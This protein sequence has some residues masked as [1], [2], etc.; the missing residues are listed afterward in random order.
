MT[1]ERLREIERLF[2]EAR[3]RTPAERDAWLARACAD[4]P[5]LRREVESLLAQPPAGMIDAPVGAL[6]AGLVTPASV[7]LT[8]RR[9]GVFEVQ[10]LLGVGGMGEVY[11]A[12]DTRLGRDVAIKIL[13]R[14]FKDDPDRLARFEREARVLASLNHPHIG[15]IYG[16]EEADDVTALVMELVEG[17]DLAQRLARGADP[18]R[19]G[20]AHRDADRGSPRSGARAGHHPSRSE[21]REHQGAHRRHG[22]GPGFRS[23]EGV[24]RDRLASPS[25]TTSPTSRL[26]PRKPASS[27]GRPRT[28]RRSRRRARPVDKRADLWSFG[29]RALRDA[30]RAPALRGR[31]DFRRAGEDHRAR[32]GLDGAPREDAAHR[33]GRCCGAVSKRIRSGGSIRRP[34]R[35]WRLKRRSTTAGADG[36]PVSGVDARRA[37]WPTT[38]L[39]AVAVLAARRRRGDDVDGEAARTGAAAPAEPLRHHACRPRSRSPSASTTA[40]SRSSAD[41]TRLAYTAGDQAQ[42]MV[43]ALDQLD[44]VPLAGIVNARAPFLSPDGRWIGFFDRL[45]EGVGTGVVRRGALRKVS[46]SGGAPITICTLTGASRGAS[47][48]PDDSIV[49]ATS[50][51]STGLLRVP[52]G[53][54]EPE[55]LTKPDAASGERD[56]YFPSVLPGARGVLFTISAGGAQERPGGRPRSEDRPAQDVD[57]VRKSGRV[58]RDGTSGLYRWRDALGRTLRPGDA[59][60]PW[61]SRAAH[62]AGVDAG[63]R[64]FHDVPP[65]NPGVCA[66]GQRHVT[67]TGVGHPP[68][69]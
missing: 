12:R 35:G 21:A 38:A 54:G 67:L 62:R 9:I 17:E 66:G 50:D 68:G 11:R 31:D 20:A 60:R 28:C 47:W 41:G 4:D 24:R 55:V 64:G 30:H 45:D 10:G 7:L 59:E 19:R 8:G 57:S 63:R 27:S 6:V 29:V 5:A 22:E 65:R 16:L 49:F 48:G 15:A 51:P 34:W 26:S 53:G 1:P 40:T 33:F 2:H 36:V 61:R 58:R 23:G 18:A 39:V 14:A 52:A 56:H 42:L 44:A 3:E 46:V 13:P 25:L 32:A 37:A 69:R 43:R